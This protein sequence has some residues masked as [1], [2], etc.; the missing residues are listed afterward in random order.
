[1]VKSPTCDPDMTSFVVTTDVGVVMVTGG[2]VVVVVVSLSD[3][4]AMTRPSTMSGGQV[5]V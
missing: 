4:T 5:S 1:M 2:D 3:E